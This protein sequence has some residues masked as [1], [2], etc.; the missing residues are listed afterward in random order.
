MDDFSQK[1]IE[2]IAEEKVT[3]RPRWQFLLSNYVIWTL[4]GLAVIVG[5]VAF[6]TIIAV[7]TEH[8]W[9]AY[10][11]L[12]RS[13]LAHLAA[14][15]PYLWFIILALFTAAA[16]Y[17]FKKTRGGYRI[18]PYLVVL[19][20]ILLS[21]F[22]GG[23]LFVMG[24]GTELH[25]FLSERVPYYDQLIYTNED[26]W[27]NT[28][29]GFLIGRLVVN[30]LKNSDMTIRDFNGQTWNVLLGTSSE[31]ENAPFNIGERLLISGRKGEGADFLAREIRPWSGQADDRLRNGQ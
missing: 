31:I 13:F 15:L 6:T 22:L 23:I 26:I 4:F 29:R 2:K 24:F 20:S 3:P 16:F 11:Y 28:E 17:N 14:S 7:I 5:S 8:D 1:I 9:G 30:N 19:S 18:S 25:E 10:Q 12:N 21:V 27:S